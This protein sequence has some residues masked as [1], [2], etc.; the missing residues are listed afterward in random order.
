MQKYKGIILRQVLHFNRW[1]RNAAA[2]F[3]SVKNVVNIGHLHANVLER[4]APKSSYAL[5]LLR[6]ICLEL[7]AESEERETGYDPW[8]GP[9][10]QVLIPIDTAESFAIL[11]I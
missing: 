10:A 2:T 3:H 4:I 11:P 1:S 5:R 8:D 7:W 6:A 9:L